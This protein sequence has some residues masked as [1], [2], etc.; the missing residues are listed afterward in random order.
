MIN[1]I[2]ISIIMEKKNVYSMKGV[3]L[4]EYISQ[5]KWELDKA[6]TRLQEIVN[7]IP[8]YYYGECDKCGRVRDLDEFRLC[9]NCDKALR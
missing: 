8:Q 9:E 6:E 2:D 3:E 7:G 4:R 1:Y 5:L